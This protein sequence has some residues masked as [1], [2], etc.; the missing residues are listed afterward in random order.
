MANDIVNGIIYDEFNTPMINVTVQAYDKD[1]RSAQLLGDAVTDVNGFYTISYN[2]TKYAA[3]DYKTVDIFIRVLNANGVFLGESPVN[4]NVPAEF[5]LDF[6]IGNTPIKGLNEF[7]ALVQ[8][9]RPLTEPQQVAIADL[10]E[11]DKFKDI[12]FLAHETGEDAT[13][14]AFL[15]IAYKMSESIQ[16]KI[17]PVFYGLFRLQFPTTLNALLLIKSDSIA[18]G[19]KAA[20]SENIISAKWGDQTQIDSI[21]QTLNGLAPGAILSGSDDQSKAFKQVIGAA[22]PK[23]QQQRAFVEVY[24]ANEK[25]P[26]KFWETLSRQTGFTD[27]KVIA[28]I[29]TVLK[30]N[31]LTNSV[32]ALTTL[33]YTEQKQNPALKDIRGFASFTYDDWHT[34]ITQLVSA[35]DLKTF[36][37]GIEGNTPKE[38]TVNYATATTKLVQLLY[39]TDEFAN[40]LKKD[41]SN[42]FKEAKTDLTTFF[43]NNIDYDLKNNNIHKLFDKSNLTGITNKQR[44][45]T[46]LTAINLLSKITDDYPQVSALRLDGLDSAT[47]LVNKYSPARFSAKFAASMS[48]ETAAAIYKKAQ[49][50]DNRATALAMSIKM[51]NDIPVDV[52]NGSKNDAPSDYES[53]FGDTNCD[54][55]HCQSCIARRLIL[56]ISC[57]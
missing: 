10:Q 57:I 9:I 20:V 45:K 4:F 39:P 16:Q 49:Q 53:M 35:G 14:I 42:A 19:I 33:L 22:L 51:R 36:P 15:P 26:E 44:L 5:V 47:A 46:E 37:A 34:R 41:T 56:S 6:K 32:P 52:I 55:E 11:T 27:P 17:A 38:K 1:L 8:K 31:L 54:C 43:A 24:L 7:N 3:S 23:P 25:T 40:R 2:T 18:N 48:P 28:G 13:K 12:S 29:Q 50:M 21:V 30:L